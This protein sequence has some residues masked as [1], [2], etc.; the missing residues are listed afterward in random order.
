MPYHHDRRPDFTMLD[1]FSRMYAPLSYI[2]TYFSSDT[3]KDDYSDQDITEFLPDRKLP[4]IQCEYIHA[5]GNGPGDA[6]D[7]QQLIMKHPGFCGGF[8]YILA[9]KL[10][11]VC[12]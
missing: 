7:Y 5:M 2:E 10:F 12:Q 9:G 8:L 3:H 6:E 4:F 1:L 11:P